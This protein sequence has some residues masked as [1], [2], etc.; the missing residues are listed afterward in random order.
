M[1]SKSLIILVLLVA[2]GVLGYLYWDARHT[3]LNLPNF[4]IEAR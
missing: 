2:I 3:V 4:K 1:D